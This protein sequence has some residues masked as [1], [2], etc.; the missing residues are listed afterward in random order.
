MQ[1]LIDVYKRQ[2]FILT[3]EGGVWR[4]REGLEMRK[5]ALEYKPHNIWSV[6]ATFKQFK[7]IINAVIFLGVF[8][9]LILL[10]IHE[11]WHFPKVISISFV[12][13]MATVVVYLLTRKK[14]RKRWKAAAKDVYKRQVYACFRPV[15]KR[16]GLQ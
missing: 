12:L 13:H 9:V 6:F 3:L 5:E 4:W 10:L 1:N 7:D 11:L 8:I 2:P 15:R 16:L 14:F